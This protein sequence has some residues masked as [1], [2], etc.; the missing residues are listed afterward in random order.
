MRM[1][2]GKQYVEPCRLH[3]GQIVW[4]WDETQKRYRDTEVTVA[5][6]EAGYVKLFPDLLLRRNMFVFADDAQK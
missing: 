3:I 6:G 2:D 4:V 5:F 1:S